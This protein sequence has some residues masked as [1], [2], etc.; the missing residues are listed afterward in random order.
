M[1]AQYYR[2]AEV[3]FGWSFYRQGTSGDT[4]SADEFLD[5][6]LNWFGDP[7]PRIGTPWEKGERLANLI[8]RRRTLLVLAL[9]RCP[10]F[11][12]KR[13][14]RNLLVVWRMSLCSSGISERSP[15][16]RATIAEAISLAK[17]L[18][19][20]HGLAVALSQAACLA[21]YEGSAAEMQRLAS[22]LIELST[23]HG[24]AHWL[25][26]GMVL[27]GAA[28]SASGSTAEGLQWIEDGIE[29]YR[30]AGS[31][32]WMPYF[33]A[34]KAEALHL[35]NRTSEALQAIT[36]AEALV[37]S[38]GGRY[39]SAEL[40]RLRGI[41]LA[42]IGADQAQIEGVFHE[43]IRI[44]KQQKSVSLQKRSEATYA[45][46]CRQKASALGGVKEVITM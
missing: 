42:A 7:D 30:A 12:F 19:D 20:M 33:L 5:A 34:L 29:D 26:I 28:R 17:E 39:M 37:E 15:R 6:A 40:H 45:E 25:A 9:G 14:T 31:I 41:F 16:C 13:S 35:A 4:S 27:R 2:S 22:D 32:L 18:N 24:F 46:Y 1:A 3:V 43:A 38:T 44:A 11:R 23:R 21:S 10:V 36:K 8:A